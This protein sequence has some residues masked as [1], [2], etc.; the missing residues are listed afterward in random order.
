MDPLPPIV[1]LKKGKAPIYTELTDPSSDE[2]I[3]LS[4]SE[5]SLHTQDTDSKTKADALIF[6][7]Y[8]DVSKMF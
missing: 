7:N 8:G 4:E 3:I 2:D 5:I 1:R 6:D